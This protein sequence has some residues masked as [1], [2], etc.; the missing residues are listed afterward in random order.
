[1]LIRDSDW[2][3]LI[4]F[5]RSISIEGRTLRGITGGG[6]SKLGFAVPPLVGRLKDSFRA[7]H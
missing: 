5:R 7:E 2:A 3:E 4:R 1:V 6:S